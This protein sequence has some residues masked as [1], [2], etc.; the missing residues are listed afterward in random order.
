VSPSTR[1]FVGLAG[2]FFSCLASKPVDG[3]ATYQAATEIADIEGAGSN[4]PCE[5]VHV[6]LMEFDIGQ[7][8]AFDELVLGPDTRRLMIVKSDVQ[9]EVVIRLSPC[10]NATAQLVPDS[11]NIG[12]SSDP[13]TVKVKV[14]AALPGREKDVEIASK[15]LPIPYDVRFLVGTEG[16]SAGTRFKVTIDQFGVGDDVDAFIDVEELGF[17]T[18][19]KDATA[20]VH[21]SF[22]DDF[23][24]GFVATVGYRADRTAGWF[25]RYWNFF[26]LRGGVGLNTLTFSRHFEA[27]PGDDFPVEV[28]VS[29]V[30]S[31][32]DWVTIGIGRNL[33]ADNITERTYV[34]VGTSLAKIAGFVKPEAK[35]PK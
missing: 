1:Q 12:G 25:Q 2:I 9:R 30:M 3:G 7:D 22:G 10:R 19:Y 32:H 14:T 11:Q 13:E 23:S 27:S 26:G 6:K 8:K 31:F 24:T 33:T 29:V 16:S 21:S 28:G 15:E 34:L 4:V 18:S 35:S 17:N 20:L 5:R